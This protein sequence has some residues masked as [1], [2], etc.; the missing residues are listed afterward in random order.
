MSILRSSLSPSLLSLA[1]LFRRSF[2][3]HHKV[4]GSLKCC[5]L[6]TA[7]LPRLS[8]CPFSLTA[9]PRSLSSHSALQLTPSLSAACSYASSA[10]HVERGSQH[11][12]AK[13]HL[14]CRASGRP[15]GGAKRA[16]LAAPITRQCSTRIPCSRE[17]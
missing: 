9:P 5:R 7:A 3:P 4:P 11:H 8:L 1:L 16:F 15:W 14:G 10:A 17:A 13:A 12:N 6:H 2:P